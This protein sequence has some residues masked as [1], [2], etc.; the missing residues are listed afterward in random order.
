M[1]CTCF[2]S[3]HNIIVMC[4]WRARS[5]WTFRNRSVKLCNFINKSNMCRGT[6]G[7][8]ERGVIP[9]T[10]ILLICHRVEAVL[11]LYGVSCF[12][13]LFKHKLIQMNISHILEGIVKTIF[14]W[15]LI[16]GTYISRWHLISIQRYR[17]VFNSSIV[18]NGSS[19]LKDLD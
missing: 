3:P 18:L 6:A 11:L 17:N 16:F 10:A 12:W 2:Y 19:S 13:T 5:V 4:F 8:P 1:D 14:L 9:N 7:N 15:N